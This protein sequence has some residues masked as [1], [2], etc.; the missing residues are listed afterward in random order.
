MSSQIKLSKV[1]RLFGKTLLFFNAKPED[2]EFIVALRTDKQLSK[3]L[4]A[5]SQEVE[6]QIEWLKRYSKIDDQVYFI[7]KRNDGERLG[8]VRLYDQQGDSFCWG[9]WILNACAP[10]SAAIESALMVYSY[11]IDYL[12]FKKSHFDVRQGNERVWRFHE[13]FG[14]VRVAETKQDYVYEISAESI[15]ASRQKY[16]KYLPNPV[17]VEV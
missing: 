7:I 1:N 9:S 11:A 8:T 3:Y 6:K 2:A 14:A 12:G 5:T 4:S 15:L 13:R 16:K 10:Q 17:Q